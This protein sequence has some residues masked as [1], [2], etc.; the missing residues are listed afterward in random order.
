MKEQL[1]WIFS[2][3]IVIFMTDCRKSE[4]GIDK[5]KTGDQKWEKLFNGK[6]LTNWKAKIKGYPLGDNFGNTFKVEDGK[7][8]VDYS[9]YD[10]FDNRFGH[11]FYDIPYS[12]YRFR[13]KYRFAGSQAPGGEAW[14]T[15]NSGVRSIARLRRAWEPIRISRYPS[16]F[17][18]W[19][20]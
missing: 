5:S 1:F 3:L 9:A 4:S 19:E 17:S 16:R 6:D 7:I 13:M 8:I 15:K 14:A 12:D 20:A 11:L 2:I 10:D 18:C